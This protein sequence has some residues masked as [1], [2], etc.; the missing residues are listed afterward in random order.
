M[1]NV[2]PPAA[3]DPS[4]EQDLEVKAFLEFRER[5]DISLKYAIP[6]GIKALLTDIPFAMLKNWPG[7]IGM[8]LRQIYYG[9]KFGAMGRNVIIGPGAEIS[10]PKRIRVADFVFIDHA[11]RLDAMAGAIHIGRRIHIAPYALL[12]GVGGGIYL[13]DYVGVGA[14]AR[15]YS[16]SEAPIDG[17]R[18]SGPMIPEAMKGMITAPVRV[19]RDGLVGTGAVLLPGVTL[20]EGAVVAANSFVPAG[21]RIPPWTIYGGVPAKLLGLRKKVTVPDI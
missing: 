1:T 18:M 11:V 4:L 21:T 10:Q 5:G 9:R 7:P 2:E 8:K 19:E 17:K 14:F 13:G 20:G 6:L 12:S 15:I 3:F 16:H